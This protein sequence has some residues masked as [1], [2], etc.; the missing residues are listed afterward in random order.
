MSGG[1]KSGGVGCRLII[2]WGFFQ[3]VVVFT[4]N[5]CLKSSSGRI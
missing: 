3:R 1:T 2:I 4:G 5:H